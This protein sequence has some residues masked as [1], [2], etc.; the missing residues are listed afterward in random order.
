MEPAEQGSIRCHGTQTRDKPG[1]RRLG[2][3][4]DD[5]EPLVRNSL[6]TCSSAPRSARSVFD[7]YKLGVYGVATPTDSRREISLAVQTRE[8]TNVD[9][10]S[11][12]VQPRRR[13]RPRG[14]QPCC[15]PRPQQS[16]ERTL[17]DQ[18]GGNWADFTPVIAAAG[19]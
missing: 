7:H 4:R 6:H 1:K 9:S 16:Y 10:P 14:E 15:Y 17:F 11:N 8:D 3:R 12:G 18:L 19:V 5:E 13:P 2:V